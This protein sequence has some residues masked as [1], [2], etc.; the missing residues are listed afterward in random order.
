MYR[1]QEIMKVASLM[2][3]I[4]KAGLKVTQDGNTVWVHGTGSYYGK[5]H[6][7][8]ENAICVST[9]HNNEKP[10]SH[11]DYFP[12]DYHRTIKSFIKWMQWDMENPASKVS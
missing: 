4:N 5:F 7:Q 6:I 2:K 12:Q 10:D 1:E 8:G 9:C 11:I 3:Q